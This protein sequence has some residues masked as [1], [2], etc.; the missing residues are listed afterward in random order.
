M[1]KHKNHIDRRRNLIG[2]ALGDQRV[3]ELE[4][5]NKLSPVYSVSNINGQKFEVYNPNAKKGRK[6]KI[7]ILT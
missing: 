7:T 4:K 1:S 5:C 6:S 2:N 3:K